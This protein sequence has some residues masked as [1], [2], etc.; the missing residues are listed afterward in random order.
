MDRIRELAFAWVVGMI[1]AVIVGLV[2]GSPLLGVLVL[3]ALSVPPLLFWLLTRDRIPA[4]RVQGQ[5]VY[6]RP[7]GWE[8]RKVKFSESNRES[9]S[10]PL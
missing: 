1:V 10:T 9:P 5:E 3:V 2:T 8:T 7:H 4:S 6:W